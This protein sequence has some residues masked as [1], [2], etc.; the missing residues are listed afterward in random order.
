MVAAFVERVTRCVR[1]RDCHAV[2]R[3]Y[4]GSRKGICDRDGVERPFKG[5]TR[6]QSG[7][8][9]GQEDVHSGEELF[10]VVVFAE[11]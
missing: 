10:A 2:G 4:T 7:C 1:G 11:Q 5:R 3:A 9:A 8:D 6:L